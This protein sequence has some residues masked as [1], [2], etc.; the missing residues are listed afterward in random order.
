MKISIASWIASRYLWSRSCGRFAPLL[1][2][3]AIAS[4]AIGVLALII[5]MS[6]MRG[7]KSELSDRLMG[8]NAHITLTK[9]QGGNDLSKDDVEDIVSGF[10]VRDIAPFVQGEV[11]AQST[12]GD[13]LV[14]QGA[15]VRG[16]D[17]K[18]LGALERVA[19]YFP[20]GRSSVDV[21]STSK[22]GSLPSAIVGHEIV[23]QLMVHPEFDDKVELIA[24]LA[25]VGPTGELI[26][27][28]REFV[29]DGIFRT[30]VFDYDSKYILVSLND[31]RALLGEQASEGWH[32]RLTDATDVPR[33][34]AAIK[35]R[36][37]KSWEASGIDAQNKKLFAALRL[38]RVAMGGIL[39][40][41]L[42]IAS[43]AIAGVIML[44]TAAKRKDMAILGSV[45]VDAKAVKIIF[46]ANAAIIGAV[47]SFIGLVLGLL[48]C[49]GVERW[50]IRLPDTYYLDFLPVDV[51]PVL[52]VVFAVCG[53]VIAIA[54]SIFPVHQASK[55][56]VIEVLRYE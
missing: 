13:E 44:I 27:N 22:K 38:E 9:L 30:G 32:I 15:R 56:N 35:D 16:L 33:V 31:A 43:C 46:F 4:V 7:F 14:A 54:A 52:A 17:P 10:D 18:D 41:V 40:M 24:P 8:F 12:S 39:V 29:V 36:I 2:A 11:I 25:D 19:F 55:L 3:T 47:G 48:V 34:M 5:V 20:E 49:L 6:V 37:P 42:L 53:C 45:G 23:G 28:R 51:D 1:T 26:P 21:L 50:P